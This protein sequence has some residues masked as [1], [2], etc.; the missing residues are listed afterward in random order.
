MYQKIMIPLD[1]SKLAECVLPY[2][3]EI[4]RGCGAELRLVRVVEP[5]HLYEGRESGISPEERRRIEAESMQVAGNYLRQI[6][7]QL[8]GKGIKVRTEV[9]MG[10]AT[11]Q[12]DNYANS[13]EVDLVIIASHGR[14]GISRWVWGSVADRMLRSLC[15]PV[16]MIRAG[17]CQT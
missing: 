2:A 15:M 9:L 13:N 10:K 1:G 17:A 11:D 6:A 3:E 14:S 8:E 4:A 5:L 7:E 16:M 12:L